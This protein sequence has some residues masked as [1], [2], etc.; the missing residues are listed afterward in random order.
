VTDEEL[1]YAYAHLVKDAEGE[2]ELKINLISDDGRATLE[3]TIG[4]SGGAP[5]PSILGFSRSRGIAIPLPSGAQSRN[6]VVGRLKDIDILTEEGLRQA[7]QLQEEL[8]AAYPPE[9][10]GKI[11]G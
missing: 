9:E 7:Q 11:K 6:E 3:I 8:L 10:R 2:E 1:T 5:R 4:H